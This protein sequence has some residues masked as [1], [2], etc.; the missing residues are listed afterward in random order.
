VFERFTAEARR[1]VVAAQ[2][3]ARS[4]GHAHIGTEHLLLALLRDPESLP[5][6]VLTGQGI[7]AEKMRTEVRRTVPPSDNVP[8]GH[9]PFSP[10]SKKVLELS[11]RESIR[12]RHRNIEPEHIF[13]GLLREGEGLAVQL[14]VE[15]DV[16]LQALNQAVAQRMWMPAGRRGFRLVSPQVPSMTRGGVAA[17]DRAATLAGGE[18][19]GSQHVLLG[20]FGEE[21]TLAARALATLGVTREALEQVLGTMDPA[22][23]ADERPERAG[24]RK[25]RLQVA[26]DVITMRVQDADLAS[27]LAV[28]LGRWRR[29]KDVEVAGTEPEVAEPFAKLWR[30]VET[31]SHELLQRLGPP[32]MGTEAWTPPGW[33]TDVSVAAYW[34]A[35]HPERPATHLFTAEGVD[36]A[37]V[38]QWLASWLGSS[39]FSAKDA[40]CAFFSVVVG[41]VGDAVPNALEPDKWTVSSFMSGAGPAPAEWPRVPFGELLSFAVADLGGEGAQASA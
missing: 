13:L 19:L 18:P 10:R 37:E 41:R 9:I 14:L 26:G 12:L 1:T 29:G 23:T 30:A 20:L 35:N 25:T 32:A 28:T 6:Q 11:L 15:Q 8:P 17:W 3:E 33:S 24:A 38:K 16:D 4:L 34:V 2:E 21:D 5:G 40:P 39:P 36:E 31:T 7:T 27:R 22:D